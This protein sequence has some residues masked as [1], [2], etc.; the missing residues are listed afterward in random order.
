MS[1]RQSLLQIAREAEV[2]L[3]F[4]RSVTDEVARID[5]TAALADPTLVD[6]TALPF[7]SI[8][9]PTSRDLDQALHVEREASGYLIR[10]ALADAAYFVPKGS[11]LFEEALLRGASVYFPGF[12][13]PMLPRELSEGVVSLNPDGP[14]RALSF[15]V[16]VDDHG[17]VLSTR[18]L[19]TKIASRAKLSFPEVQQFYQEPGA[20]P[21]AGREYEASLLALREVG[22]A[23]AEEARRRDVARYRRTETEL[24]VRELDGQERL[25]LVDSPRAD[26]ELYNEQLSLLVN[27]E[28]ARLLSESPLEHVEPIYRVHPAPAEERMHALQ[29][30]IAGIVA[31][32]QLPETWRFAPDT[33]PLGEYLLRLPE[34]GA[35]GRIAAA[36]HRQAIVVNAR[37]SFSSDPGSHHGVGAEAYAR[38]SAPMREVVGVFVHHEMLEALTQTG[39]ADPTLRARVVE[40]AN[41]S[42][43]AQRKVN[44]LVFR[45]FLDG[46]LSGDLALPLAERPRR[47]GT[48]MG[49]TSSKLH[50]A[51]DQPRADLKLYLRDLGRALAQRSGAASPVWLV[52]SEDGAVLTDRATGEV[53]VRVGDEVR[54]VLEGKDH[55]Q[56]RWILQLA[57]ARA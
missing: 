33:E 46:M 27:R 15:E 4:P 55:K 16:H 17:D 6:W 37:S 19:R 3:D 7:V 22:K 5:L 12:S 26:V 35:E 36:I 31:A 52:P 56:D 45:L 41:R 20:S 13:A 38:Y 53:V 1:I 10:Y 9:G 21:L 25:E 8:D 54:V 48:V 39:A 42:K 30:V 23:L 40:S 44:E 24:V 51:L 49:L 47:L 43:N 2:S 50:V 28:G 57:P 29:A 32:H 11:A 18:V 34:H 14:R